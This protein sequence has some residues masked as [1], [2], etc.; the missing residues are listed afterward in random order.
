[1]FTYQAPEGT[2]AEV[3]DVA[4]EGSGPCDHNLD[5]SSHQVLHL[6]EHKFVPDTILGHYTPVTQSRSG[7]YTVFNISH[8]ISLK[9]M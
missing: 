7:L 6:A 8:N 3:E 2:A 5:P 4:G 9:K 1:M